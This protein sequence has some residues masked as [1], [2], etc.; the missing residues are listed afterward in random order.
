MIGVVLSQ[1][2]NDSQLLPNKIWPRIIAIGGLVTIYA[3]LTQTMDLEL[4]QPAQYASVALIVV[5]LA[6][7]IKAQTPKAA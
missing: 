7:F 5:T 3:L 1:Y 2:I 6:L 4:N